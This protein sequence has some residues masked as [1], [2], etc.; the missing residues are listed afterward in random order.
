MLDSFMTARC[1]YIAETVSV[2]T[3][4]VTLSPWSAK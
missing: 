1:A 3:T 4:G 2:S